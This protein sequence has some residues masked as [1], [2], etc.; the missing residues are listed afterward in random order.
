MVS[1]SLS[2]SYSYADEKEVEPLFAQIEKELGGV[3]TPYE[4]RFGTVDIV[5]LVTI[6]T[7]FLA[8]AAFHVLVNK[9]LEGFL[10]AE[11]V[12]K[13]GESHRQ[14]IE[15][16]LSEVKMEF[17]RAGNSL[18]PLHNC[19]TIGVLGNEEATLLAVPLGDK[20]LLHVVLNHVACTPEILSNLPQG[21]ECQV[22][23]VNGKG[24]RS[25]GDLQSGSP[26]G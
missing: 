9:Y 20:M 25:Q 13:L 8:G 16:W 2:Y 14:K 19:H 7:S 4:T 24:S 12:V 23:C 1:L 3:R 26:I 15:E 10:N 22:H 5:A 21:W 11:R 6:T 17:D 18:E